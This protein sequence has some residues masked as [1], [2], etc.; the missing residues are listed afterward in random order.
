MQ[1][2]RNGNG[3]AP[4]PV[5]VTVPV[6][7]ANSIV[8]CCIANGKHCTRRYGA[9]ASASDVRPSLVPVANAKF[10]QSANGYGSRQVLEAS[11]QSR[12]DRQTDG[13]TDRFA[14]L[15]LTESTAKSTSTVGSSMYI[16]N[17]TFCFSYLHVKPMRD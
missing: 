16:V 4:V 17:T 11:R 5:T 13:L 1:K 14:K 10:M 12:T 8:S 7:Y 6:F 2:L 15:L 9:S 3:H